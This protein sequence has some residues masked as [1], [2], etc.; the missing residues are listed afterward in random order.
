MTGLLVVVATLATM[1]TGEVQSYADA[2]RQH[3]EEG[4]PLVVLIGA[5]WCPACRTMKGSS[6]PAALRNGALDGAAFA[7]VDVDEKR[8]LANRL[9]RGNSIPQLVMYYDTPDGPRRRQLNGSVDVDTIRDFVASGVEARGEA[10]LQSAQASS[11]DSAT[12]T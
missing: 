1:G 5:D 10:A 9:M 8:S 3:K 7:I 2:Y 6:I 4:R 11:D 12:G